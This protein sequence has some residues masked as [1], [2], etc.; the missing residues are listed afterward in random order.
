MIP[1]RHQPAFLPNKTLQNYWH[2]T[3][4]RLATSLRELDDNT[5][6]LSKTPNF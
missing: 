4:K 5:T 6:T 3:K 2:Y 1:T